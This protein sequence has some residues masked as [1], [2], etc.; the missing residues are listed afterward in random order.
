MSLTSSSPAE[1]V[2]A[3]AD[4]HPSQHGEVVFGFQALEKTKVSASS[5]RA[6]RHPPA[7]SG[8]LVTRAAE[9]THTL[10]VVSTKEDTHFS[11][12]N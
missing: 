9:T 4:Q 11:P 2:Q 1:A 8:W 3:H 6:K 12:E 10:Q 5:G 7:A